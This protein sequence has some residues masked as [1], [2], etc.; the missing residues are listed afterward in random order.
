MDKVSALKV[1]QKEIGDKEYAYDFSGKKMN[2]DEYM[3]EN[4]DGW[5]VTHIMPLKQGGKDNDGNIIIMHYLTYIQKANN[6]PEFKIDH[7]YYKAVYNEK[8]DFHYIEEIL[9]EEDI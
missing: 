6:Y 9:P 5:V 3:I 7:N 4:Q 2:I 1:W 8:G